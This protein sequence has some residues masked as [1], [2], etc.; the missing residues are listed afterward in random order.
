MRYL[1]YLL[2]VLF[3]GGSCASK[4]EKKLRIAVAANMQYTIDSIC[5]AFTQE[6]GITCEVVIGSSGMLYAQICAGAPFDLFVSAD[7]SYPQKLYEKGEA[8]AKPSVYAEG[9]LVLWSVTNKQTPTLL[10][11][12]HVDIKHIALA[13]PKLAPY[14]SAA[15]ETLKRYGIYDQTATKLVYGSSVSQ[16]NQFILSGAADIGFTSK[17][18]VLSKAL[19][20]KGHWVELDSE[21]YSPI[22]QALVCLHRKNGSKTAALTFASFMFSASAKKIL[23]NSGYALP[24]KIVL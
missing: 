4:P 17:S 9:K 22:S 24:K 3:F 7:L 11:L 10:S 2:L 12:T 19:K 23:L 6:S 1:Y 18:V 21:T 5:K 15:I 16:C 14:G 20:N 13:N 8:L